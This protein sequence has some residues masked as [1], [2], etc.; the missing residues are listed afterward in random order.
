MNAS[1]DDSR[2]LSIELKLRHR[3]AFGW[4]W[5][6]AAFEALL[7]LALAASIASAGTDKPDP[8]SGNTAAAP[9]LAAV[10]Q[11]T[12]TG[13]GSTTQVLIKADGPLTCRAAHLTNPERVVLD[14]IGTRLAISDRSLASKFDPVARIRMSQFGPNVTRVVIDLK[15]PAEYDLQTRGNVVA[16][17]FTNANSSTEAAAAA[18]LAPETSAPAAV[19]S[20]TDQPSSPSSTTTSEADVEAVPQ[21]PTGAGTGSGAQ[22][23][24]SSQ[25]SSHQQGKGPFANEQ[26]QPAGADKQPKGAK[27][28]VYTEDTRWRTYDLEGV[29]QF[30]YHLWDTYNQN[31]IKGDYP[32]TGKWFTET[33]IFQNLVFKERRNIDFSSNP[34]L[35]AQIADGKLNFFS[36]NNFVD[37]NVIFG[38]ELRH[39][40]DRFFPSDFR[41]HVDG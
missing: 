8:H 23:S 11:V 28:P 1:G 33:D 13:N 20:N 5:G 16:V 6:A 4:R 14:L 9:A 34:T 26:P 24:Q 30:G 7:I 17:N 18:P 39:N 25:E 21:S 41:I 27:K 37:E 40:D 32:L 36:H 10:L 35:A 3:V 31:R 29:P 22:T 38:T 19:L 12:L 2:Q 15:R